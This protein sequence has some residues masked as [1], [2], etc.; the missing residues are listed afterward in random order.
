MT[1]KR[2]IFNPLAQTNTSQSSAEPHEATAAVQNVQVGVCPKC[3]DNMSRAVI[4]NN[5]S[6][7]YCEACRV[8]TPMPD[9]AIQPTI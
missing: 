2:T 8:S 6:V 9:E 1:I 3:N 7:F 4:A 5:D